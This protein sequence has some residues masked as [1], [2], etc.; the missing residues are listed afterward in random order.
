MPER[1]GELPGARWWSLRFRLSA[2]MLLVLIA[3]VVASLAVDRIALPLS[4]PASEEPL[5]DGLVLGVFGLG[6]LILIWVVIAWSLKPLSRACDQAAHVDPRAPGLRIGLERL[7]SEVS[8]LVEAVNGALDRM[9]SAFE[10]ERR[11][12]AD[13]AHALR[14][15]LSVLSLRLQRGRL[16]GQCDW[17][18][19]DGDLRQMAALVSQLLDLARKEQA[20][21]EKPRETVN[22]ARVAREAAGT[23]LPLAEA[24]GRRLNVDLPEVMPVLGRRDD[25]RDMLVNVMENALLHG[26]GVIAV[27]GGRIGDDN[28]IDV[29][30]EGDGVPKDAWDDVFARFRK[31]DANSPGTG[32]GLSIVREVAEGHGGSARYIATAGCTLRICIPATRP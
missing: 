3:T 4:I 31:L 24:A 16:D 27:H 8:P 25:L 2:A 1:G 11:F 26:K 5:Q 28:V 30:D 18:G 17:D 13:A 9:E 22:L 20:A 12:T 14:T 6:A 32:L 23:I 21:R 10:A 15:P 7:P 29:S 19:I